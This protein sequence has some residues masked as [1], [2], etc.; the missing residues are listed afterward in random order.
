[1][2]KKEPTKNEEDPSPQD[3]PQEQTNTRRNL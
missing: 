2:L 3:K 1:M